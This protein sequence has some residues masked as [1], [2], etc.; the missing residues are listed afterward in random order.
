MQEHID[1]SDSS[2]FPDTVDRVYYINLERREDRNEHM[3]KE[4]QISNIPLSKISRFEGMDGLRLGDYNVKDEELK[5][6]ESADFKRSSNKNFL[7]GNQLSH[8]RI[9]QDIVDKNIAISLI[10]QDDIEFV[11]NF[12][13]HLSDVLKN[14]AVDTEFLWVGFHK[15]AC[16]SRVKRWNLIGQTMETNDH[17][18]RPENK[19]V[20][21]C[22]K[23]TN[24]CSTAYIVTL[25][26]A[27]RFLEY[28]YRVGCAR[29]TDFNYNVYLRGKNI[30]YCSTLVLCTGLENMGS[31]IF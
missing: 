30:D 16:G 9:L 21:Q 15:F 20:A 3:L 26:G 2:D 24:P 25:L 5:L 8:I 19:Y 14:M 1:T 13:S 18:E 28:I 17:Y 23:T 22:K 7:I 31:D 12:N 4:F 10:L 6:F 27:K 11:N 29:A